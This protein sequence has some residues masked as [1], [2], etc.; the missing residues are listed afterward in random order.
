MARLVDTR[1]ERSGLRPSGISRWLN[2]LRRWRVHHH[3]RPEHPGVR[4]HRPHHRRQQAGVDH[5]HQRWRSGQRQRD[6]GRPRRSALHRGGLQHRRQERCDSARLPR[7]ADQSQ[8]RRHRCR[9]EAPGVGCR[10]MGCR[11]RKQPGVPRWLLHV[12]EQLIGHPC[13]C[14]GACL[15]RGNGEWCGRRGHLPAQPHLYRSRACGG[16]GQRP[17]L[18]GR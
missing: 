16:R 17:G 15:R 8:Q 14:G 18:R 2:T 12:G 5:P 9:L 6:Q 1:G 7:R 4:R 11:F 13:L 3:Q 10:S